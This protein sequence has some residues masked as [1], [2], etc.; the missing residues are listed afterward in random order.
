MLIFLF[1]IAIAS[2]LVY[3]T[4]IYP[5]GR[6]RYPPGPKPLPLVGNV[7]DFPREKPWLTFASWKE[8]FGE[9]LPIRS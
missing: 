5:L 3:I 2:V 4:H 1:F 7:L 6:R 8:Q 9:R